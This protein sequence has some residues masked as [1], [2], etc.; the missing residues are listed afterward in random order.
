MFTGSDWNIAL[1]QK[2]FSLTELIPALADTPL[3][4]ISFPSATIIVSTEG[5]NKH[6]GDM[7][8]IAQDALR[9]IYSKPGDFVQMGAGFTFAAGFHPDNA[10]AVGRRGPR[11]TSARG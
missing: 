7:S 4:H 9:D 8:P 10:G 2:D 1:S 6:L 3:K 11:H 5:I